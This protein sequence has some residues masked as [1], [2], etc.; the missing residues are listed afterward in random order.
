M[1]TLKQVCQ[2]TLNDSLVARCATVIVEHNIDSKNLP[3]D[4]QNEI[5]KC[6][7]RLNNLLVSALNGQK[8][9][10]NNYER[11][12]YRLSCIPELIQSGAHLFT[13]NCDGQSALHVAA[14]MNDVPLVKFLLARCFPEDLNNF[15]NEQDCNNNTPLHCAAI[16]NASESM[17]L[18]INAG[19][20]LFASGTYER[21]P[22]HSAAEFGAIKTITLLLENGADINA[23]DEMGNTP[24]HLAARMDNAWAVHYLLNHGAQ[25]AIKNEDGKTPL[26]F[27]YHFGTCKSALLLRDNL[28]E[29]NR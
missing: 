15:I 18:L 8:C 20:D 6:K 22:L 25:P 7:D 4:L 5:Q 29:K 1:L 28:N 24:L 21:K 17:E 23:L 16:A 19:A 14:L 12:L 10:V 9:T 3:Q 26:D 11:H 2:N 27:A 13:A